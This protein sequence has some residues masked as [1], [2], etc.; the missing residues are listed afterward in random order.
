MENKFKKPA[1][2]ATICVFAFLAIMG[3]IMTTA[4]T[5]AVDASKCASGDETA[6]YSEATIRLQGAYNDNEMLL[7]MAQTTYEQAQFT[8]DENKSN[9]AW[10][11]YKDLKDGGYPDADRLN[12]L[13]TK[14][15]IVF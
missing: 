2:V 14:A 11:K 8:F 12:E 4:R 15:G 6:C 13:G 3:V 7:I 10:S 9:L 5:Y 1:V